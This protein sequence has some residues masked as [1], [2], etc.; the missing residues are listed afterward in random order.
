MH[1]EN[2]EDE[3]V[4][5]TVYISHGEGDLWRK[6]ETYL[7]ADLECDAV[8]INDDN[9][10]DQ[11]LVERLEAETNYCD[12]AIIILTAADS[13]GSART[14]LLHELGFCQ[15]K[16]GWENVLVLKEAGAEEFSN[17]SGIMYE[18]FSGTNIESTF[19][20]IESEID[21]AFDRLDAEAFDSEED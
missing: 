13:K 17:I 21:G 15:G 10:S 5:F 16:F 14:R 7:N 2:E 4:N 20:R 6:V 1:M 9:D 11:T 19:P 3:Y 12:F 18:E 8:N